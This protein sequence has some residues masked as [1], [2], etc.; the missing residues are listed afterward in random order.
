MPDA[1]PP[2]KALDLA[3][4]GMLWFDYE[5]ALRTKNRHVPNDAAYFT[6]LFS[7]CLKCES[8][9][10]AGS[11]LYRA[12]IMPPEKEADTEPLPIIEMG[13]P[14]PELTPDG[15]V[16]PAGIPC[17]YAALEDETAIAELRPWPRARITV[18]TFTT[19]GPFKVLDLRNTNS[20]VQEV[21]SVYWAAFM[22]S[23]PVHRDD[24]FGY[25]GTQYLAE[26]LKAAGARGLLYASTLRPGG[27]NVALFSDSG[28]KPIG[29]AYHEVATVTYRTARLRPRPT[30]A[31]SLRRLRDQRKG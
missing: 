17:F 20:H 18:A 10:P 30:I 11:S 31:K 21:R 3:L 7:G 25:L 8:Q 29:T 28:L 23:R 9:L 22:I 1:E 19:A 2:F 27:T 24:R 14:P 15:R 13:Q 26:R 16:N 12:R 5:R 6:E 4:E